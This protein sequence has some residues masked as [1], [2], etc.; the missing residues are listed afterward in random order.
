MS[1]LFSR[2][3]LTAS[4]FVRKQTLHRY[5][6]VMYIERRMS[7]LP[8][9]WVR[10]NARSNWTRRFAPTLKRQAVGQLPEAPE[11]SRKASVGGL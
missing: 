2:T 5:P 6:V 3:R 1:A 8:W 10:Q 9:G 4:R 7:R 11:E